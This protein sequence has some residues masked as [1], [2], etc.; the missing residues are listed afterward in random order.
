MMCRHTTLS[1]KILAGDW[2]PHT[3]QGGGAATEQQI[4]RKKRNNCFIAV[5]Q[6]ATKQID[7]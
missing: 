4:K 3:K 7:Q 2:C 5:I 1:S 6:I